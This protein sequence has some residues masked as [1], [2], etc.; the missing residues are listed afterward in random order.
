LFSTSPSHSKRAENTLRPGKA[1]LR[2]RRAFSSIEQGGADTRITAKNAAERSSA[3]ATP[4]GLAPERQVVVA[5]ARAR[6]GRVRA[7][8]G[9]GDEQER[10]ET[11]HG[12]YDVPH[13]ARQRPRTPREETMNRTFL[14][15]VVAVFV[16]A[17]ILG[18]VVHHILLG[19]ST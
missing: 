13:R 12:E 9:G 5:E 11:S 4:V 8:L 10:S 7:D 3:R 14:L 15:S 6:R 17:M 2:R 19:R 1:R 18:A 16:T